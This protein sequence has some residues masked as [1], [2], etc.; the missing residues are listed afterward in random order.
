M[1]TNFNKID[2][3]NIYVKT[4]C[5]CTP[6]TKSYLENSDIKNYTYSPIVGKKIY[7]CVT[8]SIT[9]CSFNQIFK[10]TLNSS[11]SNYTDNSP[12]CIKK[13]GLSYDYIGLPA[14]VANTSQ[15]YI[16]GKIH[17]FIPKDIINVGTKNNPIY[18]FNQLYS[19]VSLT[20]ECCSANKKVFKKV[21]ISHIGNFYDIS[22]LKLYINGYINCTPFTATSSLSQHVS[23]LISLSWLG[24]SPSLNFSTQL[25]YPSS[26]KRFTITEICNPKLCMDY[27][28]PITN[29][30][31]P[32]ET[33]TF[34]TFSASVNFIF[35]VT[36][37]IYI[38]KLQPMTV[39]TNA[40]DTN[41]LT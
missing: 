35:S 26:A 2:N 34:G 6:C 37:D 21:R 9:D 12:I 32:I 23:D 4:N 10:F 25:C 5:S 18:L 15:I 40:I 1:N 33:Q 22:G 19:D 41:L 31:H 27:A 38:S 20:S 8:S 7:N 24:I 29:Y 14:N 11:N 17:K 3:T 13:I 16:N 39:I 36:S 28:C 30:E